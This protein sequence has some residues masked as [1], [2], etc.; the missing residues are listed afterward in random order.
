MVGSTL[1]STLLKDY[2]DPDW[3]SRI[4]F[5]HIEQYLAESSAVMMVPVQTWVCAF[6]TFCLIDLLYKSYVPCEKN[7]NIV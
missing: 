1:D 7:W 4:V 5:V 6:S 3:K 2:P